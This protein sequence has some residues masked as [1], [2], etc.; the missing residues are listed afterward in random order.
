M[1]LLSA[2]I[3]YPPYIPGIL[4]SHYLCGD[5]KSVS[6]SL[7]HFS[8]GRYM[9]PP[10]NTERGS[11]PGG[12]PLHLAIR[13]QKSKSSA[14]RSLRLTRFNPFTAAAF[15][16]FPSE[17]C[18]PDVFAIQTGH[19]HVSRQ[20]R[21]RSISGLIIRSFVGTSSLKPFGIMN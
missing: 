15:N 19:C 12:S 8:F 11:E 1:P 21:E 13:Q 17:P 4:Y 7:A 20:T 18:L 10:Q 6:H 16:R 2:R 9:R 5:C 3:K 14:Q